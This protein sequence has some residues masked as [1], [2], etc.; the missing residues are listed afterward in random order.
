MVGNFYVGT[1][2]TLN[3]WHL[4]SQTCSYI[5]FVKIECQTSVACVGLFVLFNHNLLRGRGIFLL[6]YSAGGMGTFSH[7]SSSYIII[8]RYTKHIIYF[9]YR[10]EIYQKEI[11]RN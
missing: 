4:G 11:H 5:C 1:E 8:W 3:V 7:M 10:Q 6:N 2:V 9:A